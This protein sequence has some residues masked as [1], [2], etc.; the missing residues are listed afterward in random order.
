MMS[1]KLRFLF[2][3]LGLLAFAALSAISTLSAREANAQ[4]AC[5]L[6]TI[7][8]TYI[9]EGQGSFVAGDSVQPYAEAGIWTLDGAGNA[10]GTFS[11]AIGAEFVDKQHFTGTY[12]HLSDCIFVVT[13]PVGDNEFVNFDFY[14]SPSGEIMT[15]F[16]P[17]F[18]GT[19]TRQ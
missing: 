10:E 11:A 9:F 12:V 4:D 6:E 18:S 16:G 17:G 19:H 8:G 13:A 7:K 15:Y 14:T 5:T 3:I 2:V 1:H